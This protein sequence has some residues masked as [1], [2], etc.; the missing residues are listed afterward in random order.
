MP[1][2]P[3]LSGSA[4][5]REVLASKLSPSLYNGAVVKTVKV[6]EDQFKAVIRALL[7]APPMP[8][9]TIR[10]KQSRKPAAKPARRRRG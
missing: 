4:P 5:N 3:P 8:A 2:M 7:N 9:D 6:P 1:R 10:T